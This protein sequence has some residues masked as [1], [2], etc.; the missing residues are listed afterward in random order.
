MS[1]PADE[2]PR[3]RVVLTH[4]GVMAAVAMVLGLLTAG[5]ALPFVAVVG[6]AVKDVSEGMDDLPAELETR[7]L[8]EKTSI[9]DGQ[10]N[11]IAS[12]YDENRISVGL[13][14]I[15][16]TMVESIV[17][18]EDYRF[19]RHGAMDLKGT[20]RALVTNQ[21]NSGMVQGGS[22]ITQQMVKLTLLDQAKTKKEKIAATDDTYARKLR[23]LRYAIAFEQNYSK[24]WILE[25]YLNI[26]Y[27]GDGTYGIQSAAK[28]FFNKNA[29][30]LNLKQSALLAGLVKNPTGY[31]PT[32]YPERAL[33]RRNVV[34]DRMAELNVITRE[35]AEEVK[36][37]GLGLDVQVAANGCVNS[38]AP[39]FCD[40][41]YNYLL[42]DR[43]LG[44]TKAERKQLLR[45]GGLTVRTSIDL[46]YQ[47]AADESVQSHVYPTDQAIGG[48]AMVEPRT[49]NVKALA[50]SRPMGAK[51][52]EGQTYLNYV[53]PEKYGD[54]KGFQAGSTFKA[55][56]LAAAVKQGI[57]MTQTIY[58]PESL[59]LRKEDYIDCDGKP[60]DYGPWPVSNS[61]TS[62]SKNMYTGTRESVNT[63]YAQLMRETGLCEPYNLAKKMGIQLDNPEGDE[64]GRGAERV[65]SFT[66][67][68]PDTSPLEMAEAYATFAGRGLHCDSRPVTA[69]EDAQGNLLK[70]YPEK[71]QQVLPGAVADAVNDVLR[72]VMEPGGFGQYIA[73]SARVSAGKT[74]TTQSGRA[75]WFV[76]YT[77]TLAA[78]SMI[79]GANQFGEPIEL[80]G[81]TV[82]GTY[83]SAASG[84]GVAGPMWGDAMDV[85]APTLPE[86]D[87]QR[88]NGTEIAGVLTTVPSVSGMPLEQAQQVLTDAGF[89]PSVGSYVNSEVTSG[90]IAY[91]APGAGASLSSGDTVVIY[92]STGYVPA[93][94][95]KGKG[96]K[97]RGRGGRGR[98]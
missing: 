45:S 87:F 18:I 31:D 42:E 85:V 84:S 81:Q 26:A 97:G 91:S 36:G 20:L 88:P 75:V 27:F 33:A 53:V 44:E 23:E 29:S 54:S 56:V 50:Q 13:D 5:L 90:A 35:K 77:P 15:S 28:H 76:G 61:T 65:A 17:S 21:A 9:V 48:L 73:P 43:A 19:Y 95:R 67:G 93:E 47:K 14:Q 6:A 59:V 92:P 78:A 57:P 24:D 1:T 4:L 40:Y 46:N 98:G 52:N 51:K 2:R 30:R 58:S 37:K 79:A 16:R 66:L 96:K 34:L 63:F 7:P 64:Y 25:R 49:G 60:Y 71:C 8:A 72:G 11:L 80:G 70:S 22:S 3:S 94:P 41:V 55:F 82:G 38:P 89:T 86:E 68:V 32:N 69:I 12:L 62:G 74:G 39:F 10:G 83:I